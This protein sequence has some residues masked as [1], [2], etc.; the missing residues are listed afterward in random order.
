MTIASR[1]TRAFPAVLA[2][3]VASA[4]GGCLGGGGGDPAAGSKPPDYATALRGSPEPLASLHRQADELLPGG[5]DAFKARI[6]ELRGHPVVVNKWASWC[7]PCRIEFPFFQ[8]QSAKH[9]KRVAFLGVDSNDSTD[10]ATTFLS[11]SPLSY[12]SFSDPESAIAT[13]MEVGVEFPATVFYDKRGKPVYVKR[14]G[15]AS[16]DHLAAD[17]RRYA[18]N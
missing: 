14:G 5:V 3:L 2:A 18:S 10:A 13:E 4:L 6:A 12:P 16:E 15:Y 7:G 17:I 8:R 11:E 1:R 9:G